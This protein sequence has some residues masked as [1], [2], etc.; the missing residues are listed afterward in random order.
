MEIDYD[1]MEQIEASISPKHEVRDEID[2]TTLTTTS[3]MP[4]PQRIS[5]LRISEFEA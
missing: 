3:F 1:K 4:A 5:K 2:E